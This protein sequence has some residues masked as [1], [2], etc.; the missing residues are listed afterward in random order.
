MFASNVVQIGVSVLGILQLSRL[1]FGF[2]FDVKSAIGFS[3]PSPITGSYFGYSLD[4]Y[5]YNNV[6]RCR[7]F[8]CIRVSL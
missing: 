1:C 3:G 4:F 2:N 5:E 6:K 8:K 7:Y